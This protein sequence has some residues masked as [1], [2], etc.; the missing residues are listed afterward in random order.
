MLVLISYL[1]YG[2]LKSHVLFIPA[3]IS[4]GKITK[5]LSIFWATAE[6]WRTNTLA[7]PIEIH[8]TSDK[9]YKLFIF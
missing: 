1:S 7:M 3:V 2:L 9:Q 8:V 4:G 5:S 6:T